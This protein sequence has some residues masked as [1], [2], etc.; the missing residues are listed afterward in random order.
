MASVKPRDP[1]RVVV[2]SAPALYASS[3]PSVLM[4]PEAVTMSMPRSFTFTQKPTH[5]AQTLG[6]TPLLPPTTSPAAEVV[7]VKEPTEVVVKAPQQDVIMGATEVVFSDA[8]ITKEEFQEKL[9]QE[10]DVYGATLQRIL[11]AQVEQLQAVMS[12]E[13]QKLNARMDALAS[14]FEQLILNEVQ[15]LDTRMHAV[16]S[17]EVQKLNARMDTLA[18]PD[19]REKDISNE[20]L[21]QLNIRMDQLSAQVEENAADRLGMNEA[22]NSISNDN[23]QAASAMLEQMNHFDVAVD[24]WQV[25]LQKLEAFEETSGQGTLRLHTCIN[26]LQQQAREV[27]QQ[28]LVLQ[29][30]DELLQN[31]LDEL[32][33]TGDLPVRFNILEEEVFQL[34][35][36]E[37]K[38]EEFEREVHSYLEQFGRTSEALDARLRKLEIGGSSGGDENVKAKLD[39]LSRDYVILDERVRG[40]SLEY[41]RSPRGELTSDGMRKRLEELCAN[42]EGE[43]ITR[44]QQLMEAEARWSRQFME[45]KTSMEKEKMDVEAVIGKAMGPIAV[46]VTIDSATELPGMSGNLDACCVVEVGNKLKFQTATKTS[47]A[48]T[49]E[50]GIQINDFSLSDSITFTVYDNHSHPKDDWPLPKGEIFGRAILNGSE[51]Y[52]DGFEG[53]LKLFDTVG[54][55]KI[56]LKVRIAKLTGQIRAYRQEIESDDG[57]GEMARLLDGYNSV[58]TEL[59]S[60]RDDRLN[61]SIELREEIMGLL[62]EERQD[63]ASMC[64]ALEAYF[65]NELSAFRKTR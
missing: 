17:S 45:V 13:V 65:K 5:V 12:S 38:D 39:K 30:N 42:Q 61:T 56:F 64:S 40:L 26:E 14:P 57:R 52:L 63:R 8:F 43:C 9:A 48:P 50:E 23:A 58:L 47:K 51:V 31:R 15:R 11:H 32:R 18:S 37:P 55:A 3:Q 1:N 33:I 35:S 27:S 62:Q 60:E 53:K 25:R 20:L 41:N 54:D 28:I 22:L 59:T 24:T 10:R 36:R 21:Q 49:W 4:S 6:R 2:S 44:C 29:S 34:S 7:Y 19:F 16:V 46:L